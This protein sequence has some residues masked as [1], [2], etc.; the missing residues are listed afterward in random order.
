MDAGT[1]AAVCIA[2]ITFGGLVLALL[3]FFKSK[4]GQSI[5]PAN[6]RKDFMEEVR[7]KFVT[8]KTCLVNMKRIEQVLSI[9]SKGLSKEIT[10]LGANIGK[11]LDDI[12]A[13]L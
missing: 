4:N 1:S 9:T 2:I 10:I 5:P 6:G 8:E 11:S 7:E 13:K 12:K 3:R